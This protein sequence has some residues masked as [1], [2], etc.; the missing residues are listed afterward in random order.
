LPYPAL[1]HKIKEGKETGTDNS[2]PEVVKSCDINAITLSFANALI[3][4][5]IKPKQ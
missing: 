4:K 2:S 1:K 5:N 3:E